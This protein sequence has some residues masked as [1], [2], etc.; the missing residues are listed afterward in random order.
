MGFGGI[1]DRGAWHRAPA[2][3]VRQGEGE[4]FEPTTDTSAEPKRKTRMSPI[5]TVEKTEP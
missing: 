3:A 5:R 2:T 1:L 4:K